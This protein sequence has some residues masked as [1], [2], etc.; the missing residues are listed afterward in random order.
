M[1]PANGRRRYNVKP[2][3]IDQAQTQNDANAIN[4]LRPD[5]AYMRQ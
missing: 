1:R 2:S 5:D 3:L 4:S